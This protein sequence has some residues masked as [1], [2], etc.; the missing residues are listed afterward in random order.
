MSVISVRVFDKVSDAT[1]L[2]EI[3]HIR[4]ELE[5]QVAMMVYNCGWKKNSNRIEL[6]KKNNKNN[7]IWLFCGSKGNN[8]VYV[9]LCEVYR[10]KSPSQFQNSLIVLPDN[11]GYYT[12]WPN[13][14][15]PGK[16]YFP[17]FF[18]FLDIFLRTP[19]TVDFSVKHLSESYDDNFIDMNENAVSSSMTSFLCSLIHYQL[20]LWASKQGRGWKLWRGNLN[21]ATLSK[22]KLSFIISIESPDREENKSCWHWRGVGKMAR[23]PQNWRRMC[24]G[25]SRKWL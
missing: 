12:I 20:W 24:T 10:K 25:Y 16:H 18:I 21:T 22:S 3:F 13:F 14:P 2:T 4:N 5:K 6:H 19:S 9:G 23:K 11:L 15:V 8:C 17:N 7:F 1:T